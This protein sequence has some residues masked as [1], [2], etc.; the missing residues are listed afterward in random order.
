MQSVQNGEIKIKAKEFPSFLY[1]EGTEYIVGKEFDGL[2]RGPLLV[3][4]FRCIFSGPRSAFKKENRGNKPSQA[5][6][7]GMTSVEPRAIAYAAVQARM[8][9]SGLGWTINDGFFSNET[10]F[11]NVA[12]MFL[13]DPDS[14]WAKDTLA[15]W[16]R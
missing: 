9:L 11:D 6:K 13:R 1:P 4:V 5:E 3:R 8:A 7:H 15:W 16:N 10:F 2:M 14:N 12:G